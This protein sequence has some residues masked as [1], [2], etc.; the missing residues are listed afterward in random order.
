ML[1]EDSVH[2]HRALYDRLLDQFT[3]VLLVYFFQLFLVFNVFFGHLCEDFKCEFLREFL[4]WL[5]HVLVED[6]LAFEGAL[7]LLGVLGRLR[8]HH[9]RLNE[10]RLAH[11]EELAHFAKHLFVHLLFLGSHFGGNVDISAPILGVVALTALGQVFALVL[12]LD[13]LADQEDAVC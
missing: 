3:L 1:E 9:V 7:E 12:L 10:V 6:E 11:S 4:L 8:H 2:L 13:L 5:L